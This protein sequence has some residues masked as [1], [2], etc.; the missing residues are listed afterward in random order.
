MIE[1]NKEALAKYKTNNY[2]IKKQTGHLED[3]VL[4]L[5]EMGIRLF[6]QLFVF[7]NFDGIIFQRFDT[8]KEKVAAP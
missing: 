4:L 5:V 7:F 8:T 6:V 3:T 2:Y 1:N